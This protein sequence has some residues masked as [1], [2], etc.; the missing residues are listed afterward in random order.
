MQSWDLS[1]PDFNVLFLTIIHHTTQSHFEIFLPEQCLKC[2]CHLKFFLQNGYYSYVPYCIN[3]GIN[4]YSFVNVLNFC[5]EDMIVYKGLIILLL[6]IIQCNKQVMIKR[7]LK[8][9][10]TGY[11]DQPAFSKLYF[12][13][14]SNLCPCYE[15]NQ[16]CF[17][18]NYPK[19]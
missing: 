5:G 9:Y 19:I 16:M 3:I 7:T 10:L 12:S 8:S 18:L 17:L 15:L 6:V 13:L 11:G 4:N 14:K 2:S 1:R